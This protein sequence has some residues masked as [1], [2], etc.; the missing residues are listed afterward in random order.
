MNTNHLQSLKQANKKEIN[1]I[2]LTT[3][4][5]LLTIKRLK[6]LIKAD[7]A[8][9]AKTVDQQRQI[10]ADINASKTP[11]A[12]GSRR[13]HNKSDPRYVA[14]YTKQN[15]SYTGDGVGGVA[16]ALNNIEVPVGVACDC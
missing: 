9:L 3:R 15:A 2:A 8:K 10:K 12:P 6:N 5:R 4:S 13:K 1:H 11:R 14:W 7:K 16:P